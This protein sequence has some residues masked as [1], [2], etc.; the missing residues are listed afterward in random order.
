MSEGWEPHLSSLFC[1]LD[2]TMLFSAFSRLALLE[3]STRTFLGSSYSSP[4]SGRLP[5]HDTSQ[6]V[7]ST[8]SLSYLILSNLT[9]KQVMTSLPAHYKDPTPLTQCC[10]SN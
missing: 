5:S 8:W 3:G 9:I 10:I 1:P 6:G 7:H 2:H 4:S